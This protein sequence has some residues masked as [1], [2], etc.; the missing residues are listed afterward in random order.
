METRTFPGDP[1]PEP[2]APH[3]R[4]SRPVLGARSRYADSHARGLEWLVSRQTSDGAWAT[5]LPTKAAAPSVS[6]TSLAVAALSAGACGGAFRRERD[7][8][9][10][11]LLAGQQPDGSFGEGPDADMYTPYATAYTTSALCRADRDRHRDPIR[12]AAGHLVALQARE[13][14]HCGG[15]GVGMREPF[16]GGAIYTRTFAH[17]STTAYVAEALHDAGLPGD[18]AFWPLAVRFF[19]GVHNLERIQRQNPLAHARLRSHGFRLQ[20]DGGMFFIRLSGE[21]WDQFQDVSGTEAGKVV[22][23]GGT[24]LQGILGYVCAGLSTG[25]PEV[26][27][28][29]DWL[30]S[31]YSVEEH[32][33]YA[34]AVRLDQRRLAP[35]SPKDALERAESTGMYQYYRFMAKVLATVGERPLVTSDGV[36]HDWAREIADQLVARQR[37]DGSWTNVSSRWLETEAPLATAFA[38]LTWGL[39]LDSR[40]GPDGEREHVQPGR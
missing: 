21:A 32:T 6:L 4:P 39:L 34:E 7:R 12:R 15:V 28:A 11:W 2:R 26:T 9:V 40:S 17:P 25:S 27:A 19:R 31:S 10:D 20:D 36:P 30:R 13:G 1:L 3:G 22:S 24:T 38:L 33:G 14:L 5:P 23:T 8:A 29:M 18:H 35:S 16:P 37:P